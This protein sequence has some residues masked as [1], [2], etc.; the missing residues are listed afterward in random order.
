LVTVANGGP[1]RLVA[2]GLFRPVYPLSTPTLA[3]VGD[4]PELRHARGRSSVSSHFCWSLPGLSH[5]VPHFLSGTSTQRPAWPCSLPA[6]TPAFYSLLTCPAPP[7]APSEKRKS[8]RHWPQGFE[9]QSSI[10]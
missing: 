4:E 6:S 3:T 5:F 10:C 2:G 1:A 9:V 8:P 7:L